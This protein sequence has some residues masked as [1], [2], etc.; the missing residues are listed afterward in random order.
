MKK[1]IKVLI[2]DDAIVVRILV[3]N[4]I[5][6]DPDLEFVGKAEN[7]K[8]ALE[9]IEK[10]QPDVMILDIEMPEMDGLEV[11]RTLK[12]RGLPTKVIMFSTYTTVG[13]KHTFEAIELG[14]VDFVPKPS[15]TG[16]SQGFE[17]VRDELIAKIKFVGSAEFA[18]PQTTAPQPRKATSLIPHMPLTGG[19][20][21]LIF[22]EGGTGAPKTFMNLLPQIPMN[23]M[24][25]VLI[26]QAMF[27]GFAE[28]FV[29]RLGQNAKIP[30]KF[31]E[32]GDLVQPGH[33]L[34]LCGDT[35]VAAK[36]SGHQL[37]LAFR[38]KDQ[39]EKYGSV[40]RLLCESIAR[41][42]GKKAIAV[43]LAGAGDGNFEGI[44]AMKEQGSLIIAEEPSTTVS[45]QVLDQFMSH[46][47]IND[48]IP[49]H[50]LIPTLT[51]S[52]GLP[53]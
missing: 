17:N 30:I 5:S 50:E 11:L 3:G 48:V 28:Q 14:A 32:N 18:Q 46:N 40:P 52:L 41:I 44:Q 2:V 21:E 37:Q 34:V 24:P 19:E 7:G 6:K 35:Y 49:T 51:R 42:C 33:G 13:A 1:K 16:F 12:R 53:E 38:E 22:F 10:L 43:I 8:V 4:T 26:F 15:S 9:M 39:A 45:R 29:R 20:Y 36:R 47:L 31:A 25:G 27:A 23:V